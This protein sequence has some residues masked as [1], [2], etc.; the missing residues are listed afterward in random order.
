MGLIE[1]DGNGS[2]GVADIP[3]D[4]GTHLVGEVGEVGYV[5]GITAFEDGVGEGEN[6]RLL[7]EGFLYALDGAVDVVGGGD[8]GKLGGMGK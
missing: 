5:V 6:G 4:E 2:D 1:V 7:V 8:D 3:K